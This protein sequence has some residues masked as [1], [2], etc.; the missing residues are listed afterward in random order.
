MLT[1][2][3]YFVLFF[4]Q[5][6]MDPI[7]WSLL[8]LEYLE[9]ILLW[10]PFSTLIL[11]LSISK[12]CEELLL[13]PNF[14]SSWQKNNITETRFL[15]QLQGHYQ[16]HI[17]YNFINRIGHTYL[18]HVPYE[19]YRSIRLN[20]QLAQSFFSLNIVHYQDIRIITS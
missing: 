12:Q 9:M 5:L 16:N 6:K 4:S 13:R 19:E 18:L 15:I 17:V 7:I 11:F 1:T 2:T 3:M 20:V 8:P 10:V 14:V